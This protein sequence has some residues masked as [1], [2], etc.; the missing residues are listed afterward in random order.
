MAG[1]TQILNNT[2]GE[3]LNVIISGNSDKA[4]LS[5][6]GFA[7]YY[8]SIGFAVGSCLGV[9]M[10][11]TQRANLGDGNGVVNQTGIARE[12]K[13]SGC[14]E[15]Y[16]GGNHFRYWFQNGTKA[17]TNAVFIAASVEMSIKQN[18]MVV[19]NGYDLGRNQL[20]GN[21]TQ[22]TTTDSDTGN[23]F[24]TTSVK[25]D[26]SLLSG[27]SSSDLNHNIGTDGKVAILQVKMVKKGSGS[28]S[29]SKDNSQAGFASYIPRAPVMVVAAIV[30]LAPM[31]LVL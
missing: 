9:S 8:R 1:L 12:G 28:T 24:Q 11:D 25:N 5:E 17:A 2:D 20:V 29:S 26:T 27:I 23:Q 3:P 22:G 16:S 15:S 6:D 19:K 31:T 4:V 7:S 10:N 14:Q 30:A 18:H 21:A 13:G